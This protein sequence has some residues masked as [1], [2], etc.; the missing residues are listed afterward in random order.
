[1]VVEALDDGWKVLLSRFIPVTAGVAAAAGGKWDLAEE[2]FQDALKQAHEIPHRLG[3]VDGRRW[4]ARMLI[5]RGGSG[6]V[7]KARELMTEAIAGYREL[8]MAGHL[9]LAE[10]MLGEAGA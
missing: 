7:E 2:H 3:Q 6:D 9:K 8:G 1:M 4:Y 5:D 10:E